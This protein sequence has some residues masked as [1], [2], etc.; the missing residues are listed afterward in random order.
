MRKTIVVITL[1]GA[2]ACSMLLPSHQT[3]TPTQVPVVQNGVTNWIT[4]TLTNTVYVPNT[5]FVGQVTSVIG[6]AGTLAPPPFNAL[7]GPVSAG[8]GWLATA[9]LGVIAGVKNK[10][11]SAGKA[12]V[13]AV[14]TIPGSAAVKTAIAA[15]VPA[16]KT[17]AVDKLVQ[18]VTG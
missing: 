12:I 13:Q 10:Q 1:I 15:A 8:L 5:Q 14:E 4:T 2:T 17:A 6:Q 18:K 16:S 11:A 9:I 3:H 7:A